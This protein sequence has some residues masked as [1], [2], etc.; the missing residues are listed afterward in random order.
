MGIVTLSISTANKLMPKTITKAIG[1]LTAAY[2]FAQ[3]ISPAIAGKIADVHGRFMA[4]PLS[5][6]GCI[7]SQ[8][9]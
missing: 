4:A 1:Q 2:A 9:F 7:L 8:P 3:M 6:A 5:L